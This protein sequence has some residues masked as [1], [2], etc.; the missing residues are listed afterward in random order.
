MHADKKANPKPI[1]RPGRASFSSGPC[2]KRPGW[3][4]DVLR[5]ALVGRSHRSPAAVAQLK[6]AIDETKRVLELPAD[7]RVAIVPGSD[8][9]AFEMALWTMLGARG[10]DVLA[11]EDF[12]KRWGDDIIAQLRLENA[13]VLPAD[14][15]HLP[16]LGAV[17]FD[18]DVVFAWNGTA[19]GVRVPNAD[20]IPA[21]RAGL[22]FV[23]AISAVFAQ[24]MD[25]AKI[26]VATFAWQKGIGSEAAHGMLIL[27]PRAVARL[28]SYIPPW[29]LPKVFRLTDA[30]KLIDA[31]FEGVTINT[32]SMLCVEDY[33]DALRWASEAGGLAGLRLRADANAKVIFDWIERT[34]W[35]ANLAIDPATR[36]NT[37]VCLRF[38]D[39]EIGASGPEAQE[40]LA[41]RISRLLEAEGVAFDIRSHRAAPP[42]LR[43]WC[44]PTVDRRDLELLTPWLDW[45][46]VEAGP[47]L[48]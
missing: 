42:G 39:H 36:S 31:L 28:E 41:A 21:D 15:G 1:A 6:R 30:G 33:L 29:P 20:W 19:S 22:T 8:T 46:Y 43:I 44:G 47:Q 13:R 37:S 11:W 26:D 18:R 48:T 7:Y 10:V 35:V 2:A 23:D 24:D 5:A 34:A 4:P 14:Y 16:D 45:A 3:S 12:G 9:G 38:A 17:D 40:R 27:S 25:W 32:P